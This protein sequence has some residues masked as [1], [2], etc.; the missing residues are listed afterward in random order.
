M[1]IF[2]FLFFLN[3]VRLVSVI[4]KYYVYLFIIYF[5]LIIIYFYLFI[6]YY[7]CIFIALTA[8]GTYRRELSTEMGTIHLVLISVV[9]G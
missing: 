5:Y 6:I 9:D 2:F 8:Q 3:S 4:K 1:S 7:L